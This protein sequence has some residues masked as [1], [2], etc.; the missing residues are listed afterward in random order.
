MNFFKRINSIL[1][2]CLLAILA[3]HTQCFGGESESW[4]FQFGMRA[5]TN[6]VSLINPL[7]LFVDTF[8]QRY[9]VIDSG[10]NRLLSFD[11]NGLPLH[12]FDANGK[13]D[14]P[15]GMVKEGKNTLYVL[16]KG[17]GSITR[18]NL[19][20]REVEPLYL[21]FNDQ[22]L[23]PQRIKQTD[24]AVLV[25]DKLTGKLFK[26][27]DNFQAVKPFNCLNCIEPFVDFVIDEDIVYAITERKGRIFT[28]STDG[29]ALAEISLSPPP[30]F[31]VSVALDKNKNI[32]VL[33]RHRGQVSVF[34]SNGKIKYRFLGKGAKVGQLYYP[35][36]MQFDPWGRLCIVEEGN[37][38]VSVYGR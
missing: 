37:G 8:G 22:L 7:A 30:D 20:D 25:L 17:K 10:N 9:Y 3:S 1:T 5:D 21:S 4:T 6:G 16:E 26:I 2:I 33:E 18:I 31:P 15:I 12:S 28:F 32:F 35:I 27:V 24:K 36:D 29:R 34:S 14:K 23:H 13:L 11:K 38:R 19:K